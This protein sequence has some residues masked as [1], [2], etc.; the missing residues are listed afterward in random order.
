MQLN[1]G[2]LSWRMAN[3]ISF[4]SSTW[5]GAVVAQ[6]LSVA[7]QR[8][9]RLALSSCRKWPDHYTGAPWAVEQLLPLVYDDLPNLAAAR[10]LSVVIAGPFARTLRAPKRD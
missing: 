6:R 4:N 5:S 3:P 2:S 1:I 8:G 10:R 7:Q 9:H